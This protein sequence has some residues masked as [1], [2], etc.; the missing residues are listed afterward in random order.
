MTNS[1]NGT[2]RIERTDAFDFGRVAMIGRRCL[3]SPNDVRALAKGESLDV[4]VEVA[5]ILVERGYVKKVK[6]DNKAELAQRNVVDASARA[7]LES[8]TEEQI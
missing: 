7:T 3:M 2:I 1:K 6:T 5:S 8:R 4:S